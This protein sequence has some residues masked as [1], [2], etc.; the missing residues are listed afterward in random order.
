MKQ[1]ILQKCVLCCNG[2]VTA[3]NNEEAKEGAKQIGKWMM[4][5]IGG[6]VGAVELAASMV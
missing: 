5:K 2:P 4:G 3:W 6:V 1:L